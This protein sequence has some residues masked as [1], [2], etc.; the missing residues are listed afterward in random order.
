[1]SKLNVEHRRALKLLVE[2]PEGCAKP[3]LMAHGFTAKVI[4]ELVRAGLAT[5]QT[6]QTH[7]G[8]RAIDATRI[9]VTDAARVALE[10]H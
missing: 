1:M 2:T 8:R 6:A 5:A 4:D 7:A 10:P 3:V 9:R